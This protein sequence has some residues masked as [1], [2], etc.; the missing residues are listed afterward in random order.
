IWFAGMSLKRRK[1]C[2]PN[3]GPSTNLKPLASFSNFEPGGTIFVRSEAS[4]G[5]QAATSKTAAKKEDEARS[6][7]F[8]VGSRK[9]R[10]PA[11]VDRGRRLARQQQRQLMPISLGSFPLAGNELARRHETSR[12]ALRQD[13]AVLSRTPAPALEETGLRP[14]VRR[15]RATRRI[16]SHISPHGLLHLSR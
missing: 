12:L 5:A 15:P 6:S 9:G 3:A 4:T 7:V 1:P 16:E 2:G 14:A 11:R 8:I 13:G 10:R